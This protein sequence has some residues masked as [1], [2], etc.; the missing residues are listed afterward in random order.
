MAEAI[1]SA[2]SM[3]D[4]SSG[5][6]I[7]LMNFELS[8][9]GYSIPIPKAS[10]IFI[11]AMDS[12]NDRS[13]FYAL[14]SIKNRF[15]RPGEKFTGELVYPSGWENIGST[16]SFSFTFNSNG[17]SIDFDEKHNDFYASFLVILV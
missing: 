9:Y 4:S 16:N 17:E 10:S 5:D 12:P 15:L 1:L 6:K 3:D 7:R 8:Q 2:Y 14:F 13:F 11:L